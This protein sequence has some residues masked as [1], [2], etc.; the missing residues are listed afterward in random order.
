MAYNY[1][2]GGRYYLPVVVDEVDEDADYPVNVSFLDGSAGEYVRIMDKPGLLL[3][4]NE[5]IDANTIHAQ[6]NDK[7]GYEELKKRYEG[8]LENATE[9]SAEIKELKAS[10]TELK[11]ERDALKAQLQNAQET[12]DYNKMLAE[13]RA[14]HEEEKTATIYLKNKIID[15]L[16]DKIVALETELEGKNNG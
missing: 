14:K 11:A 4:A 2:E 6:D 3:K 15:I 1:E 8:V 12:I 10:V 16:L 7:T 13:S 9:M 5:I